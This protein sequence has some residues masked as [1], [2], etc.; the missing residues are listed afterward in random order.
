[1]RGV[2]AFN[3]ELLIPALEGYLLG[4]GH[5]LYSTA[6]MRFLSPDSLSPFALGGIHCYC[7]CTND[8]VNKMDPSGK[9]GLRKIFRPRPPRAQSPARPQPLARPDANYERQLGSNP[10]YEEVSPAI[11]NEPSRLLSRMYLSDKYDGTP[12]APFENLMPSAPRLMNVLDIQTAKYVKTLERKINLARENLTRPKHPD[13][14]YDR[15]IIQ[16]YGTE[17]HK[18]IHEPG[19]K[20]S[21]EN[22][23][24]IVRSWC[25]ALD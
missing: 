4:N 21:L 14:I 16:T 15:M 6:L 8:P 18:I 23:N 24:R 7:Y 12:T 5:R 17:I 9:M 10:Y 3:G 22:I 1:M 13:P 2:L 20:P 25:S 19:Y 11:R